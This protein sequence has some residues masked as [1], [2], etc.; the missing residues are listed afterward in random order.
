[1]AEQGDM[2]DLDLLH[3]VRANPPYNSAEI[4]RLFEVAEERICDGVYDPQTVV[5]REE[6]AYQ[7]HRQE[8]DEKYQGEFIAVHRGQVIDHD[9]GE[10]RLVQR[11]DQKQRETGLFRAYIVHIG[12]PVYAAKGPTFRKTQEPTTQQKG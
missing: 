7:E 9:T 5:D 4:Q 1:M 12:A 8:W 11:L 2:D 6:A 3:Q 10:D